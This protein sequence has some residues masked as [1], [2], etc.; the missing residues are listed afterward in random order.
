MERFESPAEAEDGVNTHIEI[1]G[2][3]IPV[4]VSSE[5]LTQHFG[6]TLEQGALLKSYLLRESEILA[7]AFAKV[8]HNAVYSAKRP[9]VLKPNDFLPAQANL[10]E[11]GCNHAKLNI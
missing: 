9:L 2:G 10:P 1:A 5:V 6:A 4:R 7:V 8:V 11:H 3:L